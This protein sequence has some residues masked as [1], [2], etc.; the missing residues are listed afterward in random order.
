MRAISGEPSIQV[1]RNQSYSTLSSAMNHSRTFSDEFRDE[2]W[3]RI[4]TGDL[5]YDGVIEILLDRGIAQDRDQAKTMLDN[6][7]LVF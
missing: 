7:D 5:D 3:E 2:M 4:S 1:L 6:S